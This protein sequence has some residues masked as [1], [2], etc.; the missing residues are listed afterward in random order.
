M[1]DVRR[2]LGKRIRALRLEQGL[3]QEQLGERAGLHRN[4]VGLVER[5]ERACSIT[6]VAKIADGLGV[7]VHELFVFPES[8]EQAG[9][10]DRQP[11]H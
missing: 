2:L 8:E 6:T 10:K 7:N 1:E 11:G 3:S 5:A 9:R 4:F